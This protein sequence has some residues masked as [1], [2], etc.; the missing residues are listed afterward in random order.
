MAWLAVS[1][2][3]RTYSHPWM[4]AGKRGL[5]QSIN[6][7]LDL[8]RWSRASRC[9]SALPVIAPGDLPNHDTISTLLGKHIL[10]HIRHARDT[11]GTFPPDESSHNPD[12][13]RATESSVPPRL[14][15]LHQRRTPTSSQ[16]VRMTSPLS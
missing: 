9:P 14:P 2:R 10:P 11:N 13:A 15:P 7:N 5:L 6:L 1:G 3:Q 12:L 4:N 16:P 8:V